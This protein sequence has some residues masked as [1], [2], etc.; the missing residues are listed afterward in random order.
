MIITSERG[1]FEKENYSYLPNYI[2][3]LNFFVE[4]VWQIGIAKY[5][6]LS[7]REK[8]WYSCKLRWQLELVGTIDWE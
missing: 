3:V 6:S 7:E 4:F 5:A 2:S 1:S 8:K